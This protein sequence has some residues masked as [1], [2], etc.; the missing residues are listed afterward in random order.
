M[1]DAAS[2]LKVMLHADSMDYIMTVLDISHQVPLYFL[3]TIDIIA[4]VIMSVA[5]T[6]PGD[7]EEFELLRNGY[8]GSLHHYLDRLRNLYTKPENYQISFNRWK[9]S[10]IRTYKD[11]GTAVQHEYLVATLSDADGHKLDLRMERLVQPSY[12]MIG[13]FGSA[14]S[15]P[16]GT[17]SA[18]PQEKEG[19][20]RKLA[21][22]EISIC[23]SIAF[24][25]DQVPVD[26][27]RF[28]DGHHVPLPQLVIL[29]CAI[30]EYYA[31]YHLTQRNC[32]W[33]CYVAS[34]ALKRRFQV[35]HTIE[36]VG[37]SSQQGRWNGIPAC[38][39]GN[40]EEVLKK[41]L[42]NYDK[43]WKDFAS[44]VALFIPPIDQHSSRHSTYVANRLT[45]LL[46]IL[47][48]GT[49]K[50]LSRRQ[51]E[52]SLEQII[53]VHLPKRKRRRGRR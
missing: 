43:R 5:W 26:H 18:D 28:Q 12:P 41:V 17:E 42:E 50:R 49:P 25:G 38:P 6:N 39:S 21:A 2:S 48:T 15:R 35:D 10:E 29:A 3:C 37:D 1:R 4:R 16:S 24:N 14:S 44:E 13:G 30:S 32:Y 20:F 52:R 33:F 51:R 7:A 27:F 36:P 11:N 34:E 8:R 45:A 31:T 53:Y 9:V 22:D 23:S 46:I 19:K 40:I 47:T